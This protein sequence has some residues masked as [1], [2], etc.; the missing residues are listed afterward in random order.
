MDVHIPGP[1]L[2]PEPS[3]ARPASD[4]SSS[5]ALPCLP[6]ASS[7]LSLVALHRSVPDILH[8]LEGALLGL[9]GLQAPTSVSPKQPPAVGDAFP[10]SLSPDLK[11]QWTTIQSLRASFLALSANFSSGFPPVPGGPPLAAHPVAF[12]PSQGP[13]SLPPPIT[14]PPAS[15]PALPPAYAKALGRYRKDERSAVAA[16]L[17]SL[18]PQAQQP[19]CPTSDAAEAAHEVRRCYV[20]GLPWEPIHEVK[21]KLYTLRFSLGRILH[22]SWVNQKVLEVLLDETYQAPFKDRLGSIPGLT[23][24]WPYDCGSGPQ[25]PASAQRPY[26]RRAAA[27]VKRSSS[28]KVRDFFAESL[29]LLSLAAPPLSTVP[30]TVQPPSAPGPS[31]DSSGADPLIVVPSTTVQAPTSARSP[32]PAT[33]VVVPPSPR[34]E[35]ALPST[36]PRIPP[37]SMPSFVFQ[38]GGL[39]ATGP[40]D[41]GSFQVVRDSRKRSTSSPQSY[42][43]RGTRPHDDMSPCQDSPVPGSS[44]PPVTPDTHSLPSRVNPPASDQPSTGTPPAASPSVPSAPSVPPSDLDV[45]PLAEGCLAP[46]SGAPVPP[47]TL[48]A[49]SLPQSPESTPQC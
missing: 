27:I 21:R 5:L 45:G 44:P 20:T 14:R 11:P 25:A 32:D 39:S 6:G 18:G 13:V 22:L 41:D 46:D 3:V 15:L 30:G 31:S 19:P 7:S 4:A 17:R 42:R 48:E 37:L 40:V 29:R 1:G 35:K 43:A 9:Q 8:L 28:S 23:L 2:P 12:P 16:V 49:E 47:M 26:K 10:A 36:T 24:R 38:P 33:P 34:V